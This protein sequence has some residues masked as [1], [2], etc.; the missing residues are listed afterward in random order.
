MSCAACSSQISGLSSVLPLTE[1]AFHKV[2][3]Q[4][5]HVVSLA[6][7]GIVPGLGGW[8][9]MFI[10]F[11]VSLLMGESKTPSL[12][13]KMRCSKAHCLKT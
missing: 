13:F 1:L 8:Q 4:K 11:G 12:F 9:N 10:C 5:I 6:L 3:A 7:S 2:H